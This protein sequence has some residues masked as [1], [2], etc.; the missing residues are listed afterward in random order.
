MCHQLYCSWPR[1]VVA[2][3]ALSVPAQ[4]D[5]QVPESTIIEQFDIPDDGALMLLPVFTCGKHH[6]FVVDTGSSGVIY[7][8]SLKHLLGSARETSL[9]RTTTR[10]IEVEWFDAPAAM[11]GRLDLCSPGRSGQV[12]PVGCVDLSL[13]R[14]VVGE[15]IRGVLGRSFLSKHVVRLDFDQGKILFLTSAGDDPGDAIPIVFDKERPYMLAEL[16]GIGKTMLGIDTGIV[17]SSG[18]LHPVC[19]RTL[20]AKDLFTDLGAARSIG[21]GGVETSEHICRLPW[22][23]IGKFRH[24][25]LIFCE[26]AGG[27]PS[28]IGLS[29]LSRYVVTFDFRNHLIYLKPSRHFSRPE[30]DISAHSSS[31]GIWLTRDGGDVNIATVTEGSAAKAAGIKPSD[32]VLAVDGRDVSRMRLFAIH[33]L[34]PTDKSEFPIKVRR[35]GREITKVIR[36]EPKNEPK[37]GSNRKTGQ[38][39]TGK[40]VN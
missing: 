12:R 40:Q 33:H 7:D 25:D 24:N 3:A 14:F 8:T 23:Q 9:M 32:V 6:L 39:Q 4:S 22:L 13:F 17:G 30:K 20:K 2:I 35:G 15:D 38:T 19:T 21:A 1:I 16:A 11:L 36:S 10:P 31:W 29:Y 34:F 28:A 27:T 18:C 5:A 26:N 37:N